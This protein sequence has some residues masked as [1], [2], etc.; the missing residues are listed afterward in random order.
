MPTSVD[1]QERIWAA[2]QN[3]IYIINYRD[4]IRKVIMV[5][6]GN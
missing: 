5:I 4:R 3:P 2:C 6:K 1:P